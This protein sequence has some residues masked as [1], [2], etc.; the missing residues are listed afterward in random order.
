[1]RSRS[2]DGIASNEEHVRLKIY[3]GDIPLADAGAELLKLTLANH[4][5]LE[6]LTRN[7]Y[8][9]VR[10]AQP[11]SPPGRHVAMSKMINDPKRRIKKSNR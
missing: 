2:V 4:H 3:E 5:R 9:L 8:Q 11:P 10:S 7:L 1:M 6:S